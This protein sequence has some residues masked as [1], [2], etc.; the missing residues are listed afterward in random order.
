MS[1]YTVK[2]AGLVEWKHPAGLL[3]WR[4]PPYN[5]IAEFFLP[6]EERE[7]IDNFRSQYHAC[8]DRLR[9]HAKRRRKRERERRERILSRYRRH[10]ESGLIPDSESNL[11]QG[12]IKVATELDLAD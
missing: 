2:I 6:D 3:E 7:A 1:S 4:P 9:L 5:A 12:R 10:L 8:I 11:T